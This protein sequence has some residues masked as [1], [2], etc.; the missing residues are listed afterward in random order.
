MKL[1]VSLPDR[2]YRRTCTVT[3]GISGLIH[4]QIHRLTH[5]SQILTI[6]GDFYRK[7]L[8]GHFLSSVGVE[9]HRWDDR[10]STIHTLTDMTSPS[11][12]RNRVSERTRTCPAGGLLWGNDSLPENTPYATGGRCPGGGTPPSTLTVNRGPWCCRGP[13]CGFP[14]RYMLLLQSRYQQAEFPAEDA[15]FLSVSPL[16]GSENTTATP[17][18]IRC[19]RLM[20]ASEGCTATCWTGVQTCSTDN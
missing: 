18:T 17:E 5:I 16:F 8:W 19:C 4:R 9:Q 3:T 6:C 15:V 1:W 14:D 10:S 20:A 12:R 11:R 7:P 2:V 13:N